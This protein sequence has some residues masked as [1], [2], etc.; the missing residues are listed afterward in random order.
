VSPARDDDVAQVGD[1]GDD[2]AITAFP[3]LAPR[4]WSVDYPENFKPNIQKY[5]GRSDPNIWLSTYY[6]AVKAANDNFDHM[7]AYF[8]L[9]MGDAP[10][11]WLNNLP[12]GCI[13]SWVDLSQAFTSNF[14]TTY[15]RPG[16][17]F[18]LGRVT[19]KPG[20]RLRDYTNR[21]FENRNTCVGVR[22]D[23]V[24]DSYKKGLRDCKVFKKIH[25]SGAAAVALLMEVVNKLIDTEE[26]LV[27][28]FDHDGKQDAGTCG[29]AGDASSKFRKRSSGVLA[30]DGRR[31]SAFNVEEFN[32]VLDSPCTFH[33]GGTH[34]IREC[35]QFKRVFRVP[36]DPKRPRS[37]DI[38]HPHVATATTA[39]MTDVDAKTTSATTT[40]D[41]TTTR[42]RIAARS[43]TCL[44]RQRQATPTVHSSMPRGRST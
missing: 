28:Q 25:E 2:M 7:V 19:M 9:V 24:V 8:P 39:A 31:P 44:P 43:V 30:A 34:T 1:S 36:E 40:G 27:N 6:V 14:Q 38:G 4:L 3:A 12:S 32:T 21:F 42:R 23:Q 37:D 29:A 20:E 10:S 5:D 26:A 17:A 22:D 35:Q 16:N 18:N 33:E 41:V 15:N 11:L 13:T